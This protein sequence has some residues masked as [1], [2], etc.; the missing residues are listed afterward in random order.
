MVAAKSVP[1]NFLLDPFE[2]ALRPPPGETPA[3]RD[4]RILA[5]HLAKQVSDAIDEQL[6]LERAELKKSSPDVRILLLGQSESGK[7]TTL[8]RT[9]SI[10]HYQPHVHFDVRNIPH[11]PQTC[12]YHCLASHA[13]SCHRVPAPTHS[14]CVPGRASSLAFCY[15]SQ[16]HPFCSKVSFCRDANPSTTMAHQFIRILDTIA[17]EREEEVLEPVDSASL[18][19]DGQSLDSLAHSDAEI[20]RIAAEKYAEYSEALTPVLELEGRLIRSLR[21]DDDEDEATCLGD[22]SS[23]GWSVPRGECTVRTN[24]NWKHAFTS[25]RSRSKFSSTTYSWWEDSS[26]PVHILD[27]SRDAMVRLWKDGWVRHRLAEKRVRLQ[28]SS[29]LCVCG[30]ARRRT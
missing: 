16:S 20:H 6:R 9:Y 8:K 26:D 3:Q 18:V 28:E 5:E 15:L 22:G 7:S 17:T 11:S 23:P 4:A 21:Q 2:A 24:S 12:I 27:R 19:N 29:G 1:K 13:H 10:T 14:C 25:R 30:F